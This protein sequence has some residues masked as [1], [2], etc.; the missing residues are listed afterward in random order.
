MRQGPTN[1][2]D[3]PD[4]LAFGR[5]P[6]CILRLGDF[7][8]TKIIIESLTIDYEPIVW[9]LNPEGV[10]VQPMIANIN[11]SF[12]FNFLEIYK[13]EIPK[14]NGGDSQIT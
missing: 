7:Y 12:A 13:A 1:G 9:D 6:V 11:I 3:N 5:A 8:H 2:S 4:N 10:G 14:N